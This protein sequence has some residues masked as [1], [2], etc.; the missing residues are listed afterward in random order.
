MKLDRVVM[1]DGDTPHKGRFLVLS[2]GVAR[3][4]EARAADGVCSDL[5]TRAKLEHT[6]IEKKV[7]LEAMVMRA[8]P[9]QCRVNVSVI[10]RLHACATYY[11]SM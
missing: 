8:D 9:F 6:D 7:I 1:H 10:T 3:M 2:N 11:Y 4:M 5:V